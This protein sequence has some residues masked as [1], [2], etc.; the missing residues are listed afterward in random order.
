MS[1]LTNRGGGGR[2]VKVRGASKNHPLYGRLVDDAADDRRT[3][4]GLWL[5]LH[6][7]F[8]FTVDAAATAENAMLPRY[9]TRQD[10]ALQQS[11]AG[12]RVWCNPPY[13]RVA[14]WVEKAWGECR[15]GCELI[16]MLLPAVRCEQRFWQ[17]LVEP[18]RERPGSPLRTEFLP[19]RP[20]FTGPDGRSKGTPPFGLVILVWAW[21]G[22]TLLESAPAQHELQPEVQPAA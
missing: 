6:S 18:F 9:W 7:R 4:A 11:W 2:A 3:D 12:E 20:R 8:G 19:G 22:P 10:D 15:R 1:F 14:P 17:R 21:S 16:V 13:S 5:E